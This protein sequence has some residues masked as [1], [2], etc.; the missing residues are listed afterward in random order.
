[1]T[2]ERAPTKT[3]RIGGVT[4]GGGHPIA[5]QSMTNTDTSD[6]EATVAQ[7]TALAEAGCDIVRCAV[8]DMEA[9]RALYQIKLNTTVPLVADIHFDYKLALEA[10]AAGADKIRIN[11]GNIGGR[12]RVRAVAAACTARGI[13]IRIGINGG[14]LEK[15]LLDK[16]G[17]A[18]AEAMVESAFGHIRL[19]NL[20]DF[21][22]ICL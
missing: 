9:I 15:V 20:Y 16:F 12:E 13:P 1:M 8:P 22:N 11:P 14:S 18:T 2:V 17:G 19:L 4:I 21:D 7:I 5:I 10:A 3:M 6:A